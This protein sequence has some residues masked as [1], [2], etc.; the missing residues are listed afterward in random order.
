MAGAGGGMTSSNVVGRDDGWV[1]LYTGEVVIATLVRAQLDR[2]GIASRVDQPLAARDGGE[3]PMTVLVHERT[4]SVARE[5]IAGLGSRTA[6]RD[7]RTTDG[8]RLLCATAVLRSLR[9][10]AWLRTWRQKSTAVAPELGVDVKLLAQV[11]AFMDRRDLLYELIIGIVLPLAWFLL[12]LLIPQVLAFSIVVYYPSIALVLLAKWYQERWMLAWPFAR[13]QWDPRTVEQQF[14]VELPRD[15]AS[16]IANP[17]QN[18][19][20]YGTYTPFVG[21]GGR[22]DGWSFVIDTTKPAEDLGGTK[23]PRTFTSAQL[24]SAVLGRI[25]ELHVPNSEIRDCVFV[26]GRDIRHDR[27]LLADIYSHPV[28]RVGPARIERLRADNAGTQARWYPWIRIY[29][30]NSEVILSVFLRFQ[31]QGKHLFLEMARHVLSPLADDCREIDRVGPPSIRSVSALAAKAVLASPLAPYWFL[32]R[33]VARGFFALRRELGFDEREH[34]RTIRD[35]PRYNYGV[36]TSIREEASSGTYSHYFEQVDTQMYVKM[37]DVTILDS[38]IDFLRQ[39]NIDT[40]DLKE[41][42]T[43]VLNS[44]II[45]HGGDVKA[46]SLAVGQ[47]AKATTFQKLGTLAGQWRTPNTGP[48]KGATT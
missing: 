31:L 25:R 5:A 10:F 6:P 21:S 36:G 23:D 28:Q 12:V 43:M 9:R 7:T 29:D 41:R 46:G 39:H 40:S 42:S 11:C 26:S 18:V 24:Y 3:A 14:Q 48:A 4:I 30:A 22:L 27:E 15:V 2:H 8:T 17:E 34:R 35:S 16:K 33:L 45:V 37:L 32:F 1:P 19:V 13:A 47:Q 38:V 20:V 44:G